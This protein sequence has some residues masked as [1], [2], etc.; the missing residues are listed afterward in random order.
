MEKDGYSLKVIHGEYRIIVRVNLINK[1]NF[2]MVKEMLE[3][4]IPANMEID[5]SLLYNQHETLAKFT[6]KELAKYTHRQIREE[7]LS[8]VNENE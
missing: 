6:H 7:V 3:E 1:K 8:H 4:V 2:S 5:L